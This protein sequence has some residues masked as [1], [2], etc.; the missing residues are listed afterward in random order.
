VSSLRRRFESW[1]E[2]HR[3]T[4]FAANFLLMAALAMLAVLVY[5]VVVGFFVLGGWLG[6]FALGLTVGIYVTTQ[7]M[8][9]THAKHDEQTREAFWAMARRE[10]DKA[11][12]AERARIG[13]E[14]VSDDG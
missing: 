6:G 4:S 10:V 12:A 5:S 11:V 13:G 9:E 1:A 8:G 7:H 3:I 14:V 2:R